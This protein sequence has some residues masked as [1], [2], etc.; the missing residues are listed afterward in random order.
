MQ[1]K[2]AVWV[3]ALITSL[4]LASAQEHPTV[5]AQANTVYVGADGKYEAAPDT[6]L[7]QFSISTQA[8]TAKAAYDQASRGAEQVRQLLRSNGIPPQM[9]EFGF[10]S[11][12]PIYDYRSPKHKLVGYRVNSSVSLK[13]KDFSKV[14]PILQQLTDIDVTEYQS[15]NYIL[16]D[17]DAAKLKAVDQAYAHA[18]QEADALA[19]A[20]QRAVGELSYASV[21][22]F[23]QVRP[24]PMAAR[25]M[26]GAMDKA[27]MAAPTEEFTPQKV[28]VTAH[29]NALF[30][31]K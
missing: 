2:M 12:Q 22:T 30:T 21:D 25:A 11:L 31:L 6:A 28:T 23:E 18:R 5:S 8:D 19:R 10:F 13:L 17:M 1:M 7:V 14:S 20:A 9:A 26:M 16:E 29:V 4:N 15:I 3:V 24:M 27:A